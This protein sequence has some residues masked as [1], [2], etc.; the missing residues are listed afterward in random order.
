MLCM[1]INFKTLTSGNVSKMAILY[2]ILW[3]NFIVGSILLVEA[4]TLGTTITT[5]MTPSVGNYSVGEIQW[6]AYLF[7]LL[8]NRTIRNV[9]FLQKFSVMFLINAIT[10]FSWLKDFEEVPTRHLVPGDVLVVPPHGCIMTCDAV[11]ITGTCIVNESMLT[12]ISISI[13]LLI[14]LFSSMKWFSIAQ[15]WH[16]RILH[17]N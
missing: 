12:G 11:L 3:R 9:I 10:F 16:F 6:L 7:L 13:L 14:V 1:Y 2:I 17:L 8:G 4:I 15:E 5:S